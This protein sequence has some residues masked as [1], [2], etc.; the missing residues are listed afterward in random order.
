MVVVHDKIVFE[1]PWNI[2]ESAVRAGQLSLKG[3][4]LEPWRLDGKGVLFERF[5]KATH[6]RHCGYIVAA[7]I[8]PARR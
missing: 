8:G 3:A 4:D 1:V 7:R 5:H 6:R 2:V